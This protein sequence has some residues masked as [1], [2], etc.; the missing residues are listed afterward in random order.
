MTFPIALYF[1]A[2]GAALSDVPRSTRCSRHDAPKEGGRSTPIIYGS[3]IR[4][5]GETCMPEEPD[6][7]SIVGTEN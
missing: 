1:F 4:S 2:A 3:V 5:S 6:F 7:A